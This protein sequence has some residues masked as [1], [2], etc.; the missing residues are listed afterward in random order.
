MAAVRGVA[1]AC[2]SGVAAVA[3]AGLLICVPSAGQVRGSQSVSD[4]AAASGTGIA[5]SYDKTQQVYAWLADR[6]QGEWIVRNTFSVSVPGTIVDSVGRSGSATTVS[7]GL[8]HIEAAQSGEL[9]T[10][11]VV[12]SGAKA[13]PW[14]IDV[15]YSLD[16]PDV[17]EREIVGASGLVGVHIRVAPNSVAD[18]RY[19]RDAM[20]LITLTV[21]KDAA[22]GVSVPDGDTLVTDDGDHYRVTALGVAGQSNEWDCYVTAKAFRMGKLIVAAVPADR[23]PDG[24]TLD[25]DVLRDRLLSLAAG[26]SQL[27]ASAAG[28]AANDD[29]SNGNA[30]AN[31]ERYASLIAELESKRDTERAAAT[32]SIETAHAAY[33]RQFGVYIDRYVRSYASHMSMPAG[34]KTQMGALIGMTGELTGDTPLAA[35]VTDLANAVNDMSAAH[36]HEGAV[37]ALDTV[38]TRIRQRGLSGLATDLKTRQVKESSVG[39][40][41][42]SNGQGQLANAMI[43]FSMAYTDAFTKYVDQGSDVA[44]AIG[45]TNTEF[46]DSTVTG[47]YTSKISA[48]LNTM[49]NASQHTGT[50]NMLGDI[51][52]RVEAAEQAEPQGQTDRDDQTGQDAGGSL[53][54]NEKVANRGG[55][56]AMP[57]SSA[58]Q[59]QDETRLLRD[60]SSDINDQ[61]A[62]LA[63][64]GTELQAAVNALLPADAQPSDVI[65]DALASSATRAGSGDA[66]GGGNL[67]GDV[68]S[69]DNTHTRAASFLVA[70]PEVGDADAIAAQQSDETAAE[71]QIPGLGAIVG[72]FMG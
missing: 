61:A 50:A 9:A 2:A 30:N 65:R 12:Q 41:R 51:I 42:Y 62:S 16:G 69:P 56:V 24:R 6:S 26:A 7:D 60:A 37:D 54:I 15:R 45:Q 53:G 43:P 33:V 22:D 55:I 8:Q 46:G 71:S 52:E 32:Q 67:D 13:L 11:T 36:E 47:Q 18:S 29:A 27:T 66:G 70:M 38:I 14:T 4:S 39:K 35:S 31:A 40:T 68:I 10:Q 1:H 48:A 64:C 63:D 5:A 58:V 25:A 72:K 23:Q 44:T 49:A 17:G 34:Q 21:P 20:P 59:P 3:C 28:D 19:G 57:V